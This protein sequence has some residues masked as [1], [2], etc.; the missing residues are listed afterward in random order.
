MGSERQDVVGRVKIQNLVISDM[1]RGQRNSDLASRLT[2]NAGVLFAVFVL[3]RVGRVNAVTDGNTR[4]AAAGAIV[5]AWGALFG[6][7]ELD[8]CG[9]SLGIGGYID[10]DRNKCRAVQGVLFCKGRYFE[11][12]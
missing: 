8:D 1:L 6:V 4:L 5:L 3:E 10:R 2:G 11:H 7:P 9:S 12:Q